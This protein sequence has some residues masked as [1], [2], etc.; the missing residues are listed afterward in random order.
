[1]AE[2]MDH[3]A[4]RKVH[5]FRFALPPNLLFALLLGLAV[6]MGVALVSGKLD[7]GAGVGAG[8][9][10]ATSLGLGESASV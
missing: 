4:H 1:M 6:G 7:V 8:V 10:A 3:E 2:D 9:A 5:K